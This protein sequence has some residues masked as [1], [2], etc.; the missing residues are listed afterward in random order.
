MIT[1]FKVVEA[2]PVKMD[3]GMWDFVRPGKVIE[4]EDRSY[5]MSLINR[6]K[7]VEI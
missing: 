2:F 6:G 1:R 3:N 7:V 5:V 4:L